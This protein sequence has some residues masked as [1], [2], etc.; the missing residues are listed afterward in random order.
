M[1]INQ[2]FDINADK[3]QQKKKYCVTMPFY[4]KK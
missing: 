4:Y 2:Q 1:P 3:D